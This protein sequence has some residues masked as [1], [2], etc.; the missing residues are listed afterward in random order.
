M[1]EAVVVLGKFALDTAG[2]RVAGRD[3]IER[4][5]AGTFGA[6]QAAA[7]VSTDAAPLDAAPLDAA[8]LGTADA[9]LDRARAPRRSKTPSASSAPTFRAAATT[10]E[11][12]R[13]RRRRRRARTARRRARPRR[14]RLAVVAG[15][16]RDRLRR[17]RPLPPHARPR[18]PRRI[19]AA[20]RKRRRAALHAVYLVTPLPHNVDQNVWPGDDAALWR[21]LR[22]TFVG[23]DARRRPQRL[24]AERLGLDARYFKAM[25]ERAEQAD[26]D[27]SE[28][29]SGARNATI[30]L[31]LARAARARQ[32]R[33][34]ADAC[35]ASCGASAVAGDDRVR[36][37]VAWL[38]A[39]PPR[40][41]SRARAASRT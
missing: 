28:R 33:R 15:R 26:P 31:G 16:G 6:A 14:V 27:R 9:R 19:V 2:R 21:W 3:E 41:R 23:D 8:P 7:A 30:V 22:D 4:F 17:A 13:A 38:P 34:R 25:F 32:S 29:R 36:A 35:C 5:F 18:V 37:R 24:V 40:S 39:R 10:T 12:P 11:R 1:L 20:G